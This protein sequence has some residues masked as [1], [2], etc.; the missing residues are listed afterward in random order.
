M[1]SRIYETHGRVPVSITQQEQGQMTDESVPVKR[2]GKG[3]GLAD[4]HSRQ[5]QGRRPVA[6]RQG[7]LS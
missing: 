1:R 2:S 5:A 6:E 7:F 4:Q 3:P